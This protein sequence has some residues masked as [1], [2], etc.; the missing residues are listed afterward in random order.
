MGGNLYGFAEKDRF[1]SVNADTGKLNWEER[2][3]GSFYALDAD[4]RQTA[5]CPRP[6][7]RTGVA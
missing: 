6:T 7:R 5:A 4:R 2:G 1:I 3:F